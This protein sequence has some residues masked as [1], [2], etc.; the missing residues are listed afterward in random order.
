MGKKWPVLLAVTLL[1]GCKS[2]LARMEQPEDP[3][4]PYREQIAVARRALQQNEDWA[5]RAEWEVSKSR[6]GW[7]V[8]AWRVEHPD[9]KGP[10]RYSPWG[11][12]IIE[13]D[14]RMVAVHY[15]RRG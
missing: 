9:K 8:T 1:L 2:K 4:G 12:S 3:N 6:D 5:N 14:S 10:A 11:Y 13:L 15:R 7:T